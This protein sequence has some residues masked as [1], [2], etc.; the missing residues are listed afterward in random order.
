MSIKNLLSCCIYLTCHLII[1]GRLGLLLHEHNTRDFF[2]VP[3]MLIIAT[4]LRVFV[5]AFFL[6]FHRISS[7]YIFAATALALITRVLFHGPYP[8]AILA[9]WLYILNREGRL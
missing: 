4:T 3:T 9:C 8:M 1:S 7:P 5:G 2:E 6:K